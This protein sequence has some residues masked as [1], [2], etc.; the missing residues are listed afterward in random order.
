MQTETPSP[1]TDPDASGRPSLVRRL[2]GHGVLLIVLGVLLVNFAIFYGSL[3]RLDSAAGDVRQTLQA[4]QLMAEVL[5]VLTDA[6]TGQRG[7]LVTSDHRYLAPYHQA[8]VVLDQKLAALRQHV[9]DNPEHI[10]RLD[11]I[12]ALSKEKLGELASVVAVHIQE[13]ADASRQLVQE[14]R[15]RTI[16]DEIRKLV[17]TM[18]AE[19]SQ[20]LAERDRIYEEERRTTGTA[21][22]VFLGTALLLL[23]ALYFMMR[24]EVGRRSEMAA[25]HA[26][27]TANL[28][29][30]IRT[31]ERERNEIATLNETG[32]FLQ[33]CNSLDEVARLVGP[34]MQSLFP[35][36]DGALY[37]L[38]AS[39]NQLVRLA[40]WGD[41]DTVDVFI[42]EHCWAL[43]RGQRHHYLHAGTTPLCSHMAECEAAPAATLCLPLA[44]YG[45]TLGLLVLGQRAEAERGTE[46]DATDRLSGMAVRQ[47]SLALANL[48]L[49]ESLNE[50]SIRDPL[51]GAFNR[52][53]L[54]TVAEKEIAHARRLGRPLAVIMLDIDHFKRF[55]DIHGHA[56]GD[57]ALIGVCDYLQKSIREGDWLFRFGGEEFVLLMLE[58][59]QGTA[60]AKA[61]ELREGVAALALRN[62][63]EALPPVTVSMGI[64]V[65]PEHGDT[66][67]GLLELADKALYESKRAGRNRVTSA[68]A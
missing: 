2:S 62:G 16:M 29:R 22:A 57:Q 52:R 51:T 45:E 13:G 50:Q 26:L 15:G 46:T 42:P 7:F 44:A 21:L 40:A 60:E 33:S 27:Y 17:Q 49:R 55:N 30:G 32:N 61:S 25:A 14:D 35:H 4:R 53:Y 18:D 38:A 5:G 68:A 56:A 39:R 63:R 54:N 10:E 31:L 3:H 12:Q 6:E 67:T 47:L 34:F 65:F 59:E 11:R 66:L 43:R 48:R 36:H 19:K 28:D 41:G 24:R 58:S 37:L 64:A 20:L 1:P 8:H 23:G 9:S